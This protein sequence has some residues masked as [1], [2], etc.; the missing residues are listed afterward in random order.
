MNR[1]LTTGFLA[2]TF[3]VTGCVGIETQRI[4]VKIGFTPVIGNDTRADE[5]VPF[6]Q[7]R[8]FRVWAVDESNKD[9]Y[10]NDE[11]ISYTSEGWL[12]SRLWP[13]NQLTFSACFPTDLDVDFSESNGISLSG[14]DCTKGDVDILIAKEDNAD[15]DSDNLVPLRFDH[16]LSRVEFRM[17]ESLSDLMTVKMSKIEMKGFALVGDYN[18]EIKDEWSVSDITRSYVVFESEDPEGVELTEEPVYFGK[19]FYVIPQTCRARVEVTCKVKYGSAEWIPQVEVIKSLDTRWEPNT[20]YTYTLNLT[21][22]K[23]AHTTG[24]SNWNN[25]QE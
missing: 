11:V 18:T 1:T 8:S 4:P 15:M 16:I 25:R 19:D 5:S 6:P 12:A 13:E 10:L 17:M 22:A 23:L 9:I 2:L 3:L 20:H 21:D 7:D 24:I 14:F